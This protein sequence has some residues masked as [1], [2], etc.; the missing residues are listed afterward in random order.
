MR[1]NLLLRTF[2]F[3]VVATQSVGAFACGRLPSGV[4]VMSH[5]ACIQNGG[6]MVPDA[7][8]PTDY[9]CSAWDTKYDNKPMCGDVWYGSA[10]YVMPEACEVGGGHYERDVASA[11]GFYCLGGI[12]AGDFVSICEASQMGCIGI[13]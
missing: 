13:R 2:L 6:S 7:G 5:D 9:V 8:S 3:L 11:T 10:Y 4:S 12:Y 1:A